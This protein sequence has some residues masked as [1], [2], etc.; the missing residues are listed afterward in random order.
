MIETGFNIGSLNI[1][2]KNNI[3]KHSNN[4]LEKKKSVQTVH[5]FGRI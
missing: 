3:P 5:K 4:F 2:K 1:S